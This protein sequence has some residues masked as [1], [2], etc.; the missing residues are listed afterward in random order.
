LVVVAGLERE[1]K[2]TIYNFLFSIPKIPEIPE[3]PELPELPELLEL[4][5]RSREKKKVFSA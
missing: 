1:E 4:H 3:I 5:G 2:F